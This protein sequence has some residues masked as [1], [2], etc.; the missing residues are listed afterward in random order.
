MLSAIA[1][2]AAA[3]ASVAVAG[4]AAVTTGV[5]PHGIEVALQHVPDWTHAHAV[6]E[7]IEKVFAGGGHPGRAPPTGQ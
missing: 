2:K 3:A 4:T 6:L 5:V 7:A 1:L